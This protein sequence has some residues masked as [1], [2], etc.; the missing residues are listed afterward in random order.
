MADEVA[1]GVDNWFNG[2][3]DVGSD[4]VANGGVDGVDGSS[5][6]PQ[7]GPRPPHAHV[8]AEGA[9]HDKQNACNG[10]SQKN[11]V[12]DEHKAR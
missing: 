9:K 2:S 6:R 7:G 10:K 4:G 11:D 1:D 5:G 12:E 8:N 3:C